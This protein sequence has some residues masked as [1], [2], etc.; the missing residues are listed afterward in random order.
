MLNIFINE[1][2]KIEVDYK[3]VDCNQESAHCHVVRGDERVAKVLV[4][5]VKI[6][7][8]HSLE[9]NEIDMVIDVVSANQSLIRDEYEY[10]K[11]NSVER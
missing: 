1:N 10:N 3:K 7:S 11:E 5:P 2:L 9:Q 4:N 6:E 8:G